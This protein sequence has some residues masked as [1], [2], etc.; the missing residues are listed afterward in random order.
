MRCDRRV[1]LGVSRAGLSEWVL[2]AQP[3]CD[4]VVVIDETQSFDHSR[5]PGELDCG[6]SV[7]DVMR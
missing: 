3:P 2:S 1:T 6:R 5:S 4:A 7:Q